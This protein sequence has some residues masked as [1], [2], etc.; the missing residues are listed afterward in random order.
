LT[1]VSDGIY[2]GFPT[3]SSNGTNIIFL[4]LRDD[5]V[6]ELYMMKAS[7]GSNVVRLTFDAAFSDGQASWHY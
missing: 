1:T 2:D 5:G 3:W 4:S 6:G 7:D